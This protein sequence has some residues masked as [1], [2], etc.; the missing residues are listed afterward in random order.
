MR[1][2]V[3]GTTAVAFALWASS[4]AQAQVLTAAEKGREPAP[5]AA[6]HPDEAVKKF[7]V[8]DGFEVRLFAA[9]PDVVN[10]VAMTWDD[11]GR[12]WVVELVDYPYSTTDKSKPP[13]KLGGDRVKV[14]EDTDGDGR[15]D[16]VTVFAEGLNMATAIAVGDGGVYVGAAP[17]LWF[18]KD[19]TGDDVADEK[20]VVLTGFGVE[21]R[22]ETL[23]NFRW[24]PDGW[25]YFTHGVFTHSKVRDPQRPDAPEVKFNA[26]VMRLDTRTKRL[27][28]FA[29]GISNQWG[30]DW[31]AAGNAFVSACV[32][33][34]LWHVVPG[35]IYVRQ[36]GVPGWPHAYDLLKHVNDHKHFRAA[37]SGI[38]VYQGGQ[39]P[40]EYDGT[41]FMGNIHGNC[42]NH[43]KLVAN[44][45]SFTAQ[46][47]HR[48]THHHDDAFL[49]STDGWFR[50]VS[51][52]TGPDGNLW[53][54]DWYDKYPCYQNAR[55][56]DLDRSRGRIWR[57]V[58]TG[59]DK[60]KKI[61]ARPD[62]LDLAKA[63]TADLVKLLADKNNWTRRQAQRVLSEREVDLRQELGAVL[64]DTK[65]PP[66]HRMAALW[67][68]H[69]TG[70]LNNGALTTLSDHPD[71]PVRA[72]VARLIGDR[73]AAGQV[74]PKSSLTVVL[75]KLAGSPSP[76]VRAGVATAAKQFATARIPGT[77]AI[78]QRLLEAKGTAADPML[79]QLIWYAAEPLLAQD[80]RAI[81]SWLAEN[82]QIV[83]AS[84]PLVPRSIARRL[85]ASG[86]KES[87]PTILSFIA[88]LK[89][90]KQA[91]LAAAMVDGVLAGHKKFMPAP[92]G[93]EAFVAAMKD[94]KGASDKV[95]Q[96]ATMWGD[97]SG[98][99]A[100]VRTVGDAKAS[101][102]DRV[103]AVRL[104]R[105]NKSD[106]VRKAL[107]GALTEGRKEA[108]KL[109]VFTSLRDAGADGDAS[110]V[111]MNW[112]KFTATEVRRAAAEMLA[113]RPAW[114]KAL[115]RAVQDKK[116]DAAD[117][118]LPALRLLS[119]HAGRDA[120]LKQLMAATLGAYRESPAD[121]KKLIEAK[122]TV[123]MAGPADKERG[124]KLFLQHCGT[125]HQLNGE[126]AN[127]PVGPDI[128][129]VG[130]G[131]LD[132][133][134]NNV[135]D[136]D[137]IIG[138]GYENV[139]VE[140]TDGDIKNGRLV[141]E[142]PQYVKLLAAGPKEEVIPKKDIKEKRISA[143]S[144][145]PEGF[146]QIMKDEEFRDLM[147]FVLEAPV[148]Q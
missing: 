111:L 113:A 128:T 67:T 60:G 37:Y 40:P 108:L 20:R 121:K 72:W 41:I 31:D 77:S 116:V 11:R 90:E 112:G 81:L 146:D 52:Q 93:A 39:Y 61:P 27:E 1:K 10:P 14:L 29:D 74:D 125:C 106:D 26:A 7:R 16:K 139:I 107:L 68:L 6:L 64:A 85:Y 142:T 94:H 147:R 36:A 109:E 62:G 3:L 148:K 129:G 110:T 2:T 92:A 70:G 105:G 145:M 58:Y 22:H 15:A 127:P 123:V 138:A 23:N 42:I 43:D 83:D 118:P 65:T 63:N 132:L 104:L 135:L 59:A 117:I 35:G 51:T 8:P 89:D 119:D 120:E 47:L 134:L 34:H 126:G 140:T 114:A 115:L 4:P 80:P 131:T 76:V 53:I 50:P 55:Q 17:N 38:Q 78:V 5:S 75:A 30:V 49:N 141:E 24:G 21:D 98:V 102:D 48:G 19:T 84:G 133:L 32:V 82:P 12:L 95:K 88:S 44:G 25:L 18:M 13:I 9:E 54:C 122:K 87:I 56:P 33:E 91:A 45:S 101:D 73:A 96:L 97:K 71:E 46:D 130:R 86:E 57:V 66:A 124:H 99:A 69:S 79:P 144:A 28:K 103:A 137:Q 143:K 100:A 136:P